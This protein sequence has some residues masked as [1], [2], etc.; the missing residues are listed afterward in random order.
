MNDVNLEYVSDF[1]KPVCDI[2]KETKFI[3][4]YQEILDNDKIESVIIATPTDTHYQ[5]AKESLE[6]GKNVLVEKPL[7]TKANEARILC[8][9]ADSME[10]GLMVGE[11]FRF[12]QAVNFIKDE[13][14]QCEIGDVRYIE[15]RRVGLGP[16]RTDVS[17]LWDLATHDIYLSNM[18]VG[19][20][21]DSVTCQG[22]SHNGELDDIC[23]LN[24]KYDNKNVLS[25]IYVNWEHPIK[26]RKTII[27][28]TKKAILFDDVEPSK[29]VTIYE[30][31][32]DYQP[33]TSD[34]G[35]FQAATR[36]GAIIIPKINLN[37]PLEAEL[38]EFIDYSRDL[39]LNIKS[40]GYDGLETLKVLE[41]AEESRKNNGLEIRLK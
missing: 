17:A 28:G 21:P 16:I 1:K 10:K 41:A 26:E 22:I 12:N 23:C 25:S 15:S 14:N 13:I 7:T 35:A 4:D 18:F 39:T 3:S 34:F 8:E 19:D 2:P 11:I 27:G 32:V 40:T 24:M 38:R 33:K 31:G 5:L 29:K 37:Q 30:S 6:A 20:T 9:V 36:D